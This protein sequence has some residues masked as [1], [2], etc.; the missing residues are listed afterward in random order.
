MR[1]QNLAGLET[2]DVLRFLGFSINL[3]TGEFI[4][5]LQKGAA[6]PEVSNPTMHHQITELL[7]EYSGAAKKP[8]SGKQVNFRGFPGGVAYENAFVRKAVDPVAKAFA[9]CPELLVE[10]GV[11]LG[12]KRLELGQASIEIPAFNLV[13]ITYI[14]WVDEE[15]PPTANVLYDESANNYLNA[16]GLANLAELATWRLLLAKKLMQNP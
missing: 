14:L 5:E 10:A 16:E 13:P 12:G 7:V 1:L 11:L 2:A 8:L 4:D 6:N 3:Q 9:A 15:L